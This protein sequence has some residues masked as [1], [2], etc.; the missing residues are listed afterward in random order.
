[1]K[2]TAAKRAAGFTTS[3][4]PLARFFNWLNNLA[5]QWIVY[6]DVISGAGSWGDG[7]HGN[8]VA[9]GAATLAAANRVGSVYTLNQD[10]FYHNLTVSAGAQIKT[11]GFRI[12]VK[13]KLTTT[14][15]GFISANGN[16][17]A[18]I[19]VAGVATAANTVAGGSA[20]GAGGA[21][22]FGANGSAATQSEGGGGGDGGSAT[23]RANGVGGVITFVT[24]ALGILSKA[25]TAMLMGYSIG[26]GTLVAI[27]GGT[28]GGG[29][30]GLNGTAT[31]GGGGSGGGVLCVSAREINLQNALSL[32]AVGGDG[33]G[34]VVGSG[35]GAAGGGGGG[36]GTIQIAYLI[37]TSATTFNYATQCAGGAGGA[38]SGAGGATVGQA[39]AAGF[40]REINLG[41]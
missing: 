10:A 5:Y 14:G 4:R 2:P 27:R 15:G 29:G 25:Y 40:I 38:I 41:P 18:G 8:G 39:G 16:A 17:G 6:F 1:M 37:N 34:G 11:N 36:G 26:S 9:D 21:D 30:G 12:Y 22:T 32:R 23:G 33:G 31:G 24:A 20:G 7:S 19:G 13:G 28:G 3:E 35:T